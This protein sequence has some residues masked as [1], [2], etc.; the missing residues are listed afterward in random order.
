MTAQ[1]AA[2]DRAGQ[3]LQEARRE[4]ED[5]TRNDNSPERVHEFCDP[6]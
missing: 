2:H 6:R 4:Y 5:G 3:V 1:M